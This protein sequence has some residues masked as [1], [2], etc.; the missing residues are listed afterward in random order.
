MLAW[1]RA[2]SAVSAASARRIY[3]RESSCRA[4]TGLKDLPPVAKSHPMTTLPEAVAR[5]EVLALLHP[6]LWLQ[7]DRGDAGLGGS[8]GR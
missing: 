1:L 7:P 3:G 5:I 8:A 4:W 2:T 6:G